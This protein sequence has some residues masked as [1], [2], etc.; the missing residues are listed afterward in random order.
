MNR[1]FRKF[2]LAG[3]LLASAHGLL[4]A[5]MTFDPLP[6]D[7]ADHNSY[8]ENGIT[9][10][11]V[12]PGEFFRADGVAGDTSAAIYSFDGDPFELTFGPGPFTLQSIDF[13]DFAADTVALLTSSSGGS[14]TVSSIGTFA[15]GA[16]FE[17]VDWVRLSFSQASSLDPYFLVDNILVA[18]SSSAVPDSGSLALLTGLSLAALAWTHR[19]TFVA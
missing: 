2:Q 13:E 15:P 16:G 9:I 18:S 11:A 3:V 17:N 10:A 12:D 6:P 14:V 7:F 1:T 8:S 4:A 19:R 5:S